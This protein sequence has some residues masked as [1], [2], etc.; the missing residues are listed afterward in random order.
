M[1]PVFKKMNYKAQKV[2]HTI[3]SSASFEKDLKEMMALAGIKKQ[4]I[5]LS[6]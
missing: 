4:R 5:K 6:L 2:I 1:N 3:N